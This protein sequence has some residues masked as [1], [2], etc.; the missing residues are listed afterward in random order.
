MESKLGHMTTSWF[1]DDRQFQ[2]SRLNSSSDAN[3][4]HPARFPNRTIVIGN[5]DGSERSYNGHPGTLPSRYVAK[6]PGARDH[7]TRQGRLGT[8]GRRLT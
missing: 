5:A 3:F 6:L 1:T 8:L 2:Q 4:H 7:G